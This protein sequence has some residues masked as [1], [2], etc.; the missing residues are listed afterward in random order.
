[1]KSANF[2]L[3]SRINSFKYAINGL[4]KLL[5]NE[6]NFRV[7]LLAALSAIAFGIVL[8]ITRTEWCILIIVTGIVFITEALNSSLEC[9]ADFVNPEWNEHIQKA[10]DYSA[11]AVLIS[12]VIALISG[13]L[14]F[15]PKIFT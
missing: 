11:A 13:A 4:W 10:K 6:H 9:L 5:K 2:S 14:I 7:H 15:L 3:K 1:M 12:A 8:H